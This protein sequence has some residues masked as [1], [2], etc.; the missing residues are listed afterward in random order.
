MISG[1]AE[2]ICYT[3]LVYGRVNKKLKLDS[4][5]QEIEKMVIDILNNPHSKV[6]KTGKNFYVSD[7]DRR[8]RLTVNS[9]NYRLI[10]ADRI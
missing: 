5:N 8:V 3:D 4:S 1:I 7:S 9:F 2:N 6:V 10:T